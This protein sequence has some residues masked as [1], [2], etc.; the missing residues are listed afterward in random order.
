MLHGS[1]YMSFT[2][3]CIN[4]DICIMDRLYYLSTRELAS[5]SVDNVSSQLN[6]SYVFAGFQR[7]VRDV[8]RSDD[9]V[10]AVV[11]P[12]DSPANPVLGMRGARG[13]RP[14]AT[15]GADFIDGH[16]IKVGRRGPGLAVTRAAT[17][18]NNR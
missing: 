9:D 17:T 7:S 10:G 16:F 14:A 6:S 5:L 11:G 12:Q 2:S 4:V 8:G 13:H 15:G 1:E 18:R 3:S